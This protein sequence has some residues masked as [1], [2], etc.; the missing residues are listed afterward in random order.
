MNNS[1]ILQCKL[2]V[3]IRTTFTLVLLLSISSMYANDVPKV[4]LGI[5]DKIPDAEFLQQEIE[6]TGKVVSAGDNLSVP[7]VNVILKGTSTGVVTDFDGNFKITVPSENSVL[8]FSFIGFATQEITVGGNTE[9]NISL[10]EDASAL[11][12]IVVVG[13]G[14]VKKESLTGA[15]EQVKSEAFEDRA[16]TNPALSLQGQSPGLVVSRSSPRPGNE[17]INLQ[18]RGATSVNG[19]EPLVVI[20]GV[21]VIGLREFYQMNYDDIES[22]SVLKD[23]SASIYGSRASNGV[24]LVTTKKGKGKMSVEYKGNFRYNTIGI[25]PPTPSMQEYATLWLD[26]VGEDG[27]NDYWGW[28]SKENLERMQTGEEGIYTTPFWGDIYIGNAPRFDE[29]FGS[30]SSY[31]HNLSISGSSEKTNYRLSASFAD[32]KGALKTAYDGQKQYNIRF[33]NDYNISDRV[34]LHSGVTYQRSVTSGPSTGLDVTAGTSDPPFFPALNPYGQWYA[35]FNIAGNRNSTAATTDGGRQDFVE[36]LTK[37]YLNAEVKIFEDLTARATG[38]FN[39]RLGR[40]DEYRLTVQPYTWNGEVSA[41]RI[42]STPLIAARVYDRT[43]QNYGGFLDYKKSFGDHNLAAMVGVTSDLEEDKYLYA[44]RS[45]IED[46]GV[47]D[48]NVAPQDN[49]RNGGGSSHWGLYSYLSRIN[50]DYQGKYLLELIGRRDGSSRFDPDFRWS[51]FGSVSAGWI[52]SS[53][54][55]MNNL[56]VISFAKLRSSYGEMGN[57]VGIGLYDYISGISRGSHPFGSTPSIQSTARVSGLTS[58]TRTW[59]RV[60]MTNFGFDF[61]LLDHRLNGSF[62]YYIKE[63]KGMLTNI[64]Y[65]DVLGGTAPRSNSGNL[66]TKGWEAMLGWKDRIGDDFSYNISANMSDNNN[67]IVKLEGASGWNAGSVGTREG[68]PINSYFLYETDG[69]FQNQAEVD[70][71]YEEFTSTTQGEIPIQSDPF[72]AL[73]PGDIRKVDLD[74]NGYID[75]IGG[76]GD[77]GDVK[78]MGDAAPHYVFGINMGAKW[79]GFDLNAFFQGVLE[80]NVLRTGYTPYPFYTVYTNQNVSYQGKTWTATNTDAA[81]PRLTTNT[82]RARYNWGNND[83]SLQNSR[84]IRLKTLVVGYTLPESISDKLR[85]EKIRFN[86]SGNDLFEA[87][88]IKDGYDPEFGESTQSIY[89]FTRTFALGVNVTF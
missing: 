77:S 72:Q 50:Y 36:D 8:V 75:D 24:I 16:I 18:I 52:I 3:L 67:K 59:E 30:S 89:P 65:P 68:Y 25:R 2:S 22:V 44:E 32:T 15:V 69:L 86:F 46:F 17:G 37:I 53:E 47:Y 81:Y 33:N 7:S 51:N 27:T 58:N 70:A 43:Y 76:Q 54:K 38:S 62:D 14:S 83:F 71:Y 73:R 12:E 45:G 19:G 11:D 1:K 56:P 63:N 66:E 88:T 84:Y 78:F 79:K 10:Q 23:G 85:M 35:N 31:Q 13:Y 48:L 4:S 55:F 39:K 42:N 61:A 21:P 74:G 9:I 26:A 41:E 6:V 29:L 20:D 28:A 49:M 57:Q 64:I 5:S 87:T 80:Q 60:V 34:T 82:N 40:K